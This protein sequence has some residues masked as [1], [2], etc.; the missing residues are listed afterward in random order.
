MAEGH[1]HSLSFKIW[2]TVATF[3]KTYFRNASLKLPLANIIL[4]LCLSWHCN[5]QQRVFDVHLHGSKEPRTQL[6]NLMKAGVYKVAISTSQD[7]QQQYK[8]KDDLQVLR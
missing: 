3:R 7:L 5:A 2:K 4:F 6:E 1:F 8:K